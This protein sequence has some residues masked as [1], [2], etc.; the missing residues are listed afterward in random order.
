MILVSCLY[1][2]KYCIKVCSTNDEYIELRKHP[3][4]GYEALKNDPSIK[5][6]TKV[7]VYMHHEK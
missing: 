6:V 7:I 1:Q 3:L 4:Y 5:P 2:M